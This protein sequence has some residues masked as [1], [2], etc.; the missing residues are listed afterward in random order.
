[1]AQA[2]AGGI[3]Y[4]GVRE[5]DQG[6][7]RALFWG[8]WI[9]LITTAFGFITRMFLIGTWA[10]E[11]GL[12]DAQ[13]GRLAGIGIWPFAVSIIAFSLIIDRI[14]YKTAM[15]ISFLGYMIWSV[16]GVSAFYVSRGGNKEGAFQML[17]WGSL[18]L[19]LSNGTVE[20]YIN[21]VVAT[22]FNREKTK[23]LNILHA[24]W[25][26]GLVLAGLITISIDTLAPSTPWS[27][28]V[29]MIAI[30]AVVFFFM[31][32]GLKFPVQERVAAGVSYRDMLAEFGIMGALVVGF[33]VVL[34][35]MDFFSGSKAFQGADGSLAMWAK[36]LFMAIGVVIVAGFAAYT[37]SLGRG[38]MFFMIIIMMPLATTELGT[39]GW[40]TAIM[41]GTLKGHHPGWVL[42]YTSFIMMVLRFC[43][44]PIIHKLSP[45]GLLALS[46]LLAI[47]GL[48]FL[49]GATGLLMIFGAA[50]LYA[51]GKTFF[52]P[53]MLG[54]VSDQTPR[55]GALTL[56]AL[57]GIGMLAV[58]V[59]GFP[60]I[61]TL[62]AAKNI[63]A[64]AATPAAQS[65]PALV[66]NGTLSETVLDD[67]KV[68]EIIPY[69]TVNDAK[70][71]AM[72]ASLP[73][74]KKQQITDA[75][76][77]SAQ[78]ALGNM[79]RFPMFMLACYIIL[80]IYFRTRGGYSAQVLTGHA[81]EDKKFTG[82]VV[83]PIE[84]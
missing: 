81:A 78:K 62:K 34:Q 84:A 38:F 7:N 41:E 58:G 33:L 63:D 14:G 74:D 77:G 79:A 45:L 35:L 21:P 48:T 83:G 56:N 32:I 23:W 4:S 22:I 49:S 8:C 20:A 80:I 19:G 13:S 75:S 65:V 43:A 25:P 5:I 9:A 55:G 54:V 69:K 47:L 16:M 39:D 12:D 68:Y 44:G 66:A 36:V 18:I 64:I 29:G 51:C 1:M 37:K 3:D 67:K 72:I 28:K 50:T 26:G 76:A 59:L 27:I 15:I 57:G 24:G 40:I 6:Q 11:F 42:V 82:G 2:T 61:G 10:K 70:L 17:Y 30:P 31:L 73:T 52:W 53:T 46:A 60:Y 71:N